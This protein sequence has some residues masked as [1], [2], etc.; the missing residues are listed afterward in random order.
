MSGFERVEFVLW[1]NQAGKVESSREPFM[2]PSGHVTRVDIGGVVKEGRI[3]SLV[4]PSQGACRC[5]V[6][7]MTLELFAER[8]MSGCSP[9]SRDGSKEGCNCSRCDGRS[10]GGL[11]KDAKEIS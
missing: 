6:V 8:K 10:V 11:G 3:I 7:N 5:W 2:A 1:T 9:L 4:C